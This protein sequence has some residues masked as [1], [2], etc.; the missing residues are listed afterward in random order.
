MVILLKVVKLIVD[1][2]DGM[3]IDDSSIN[4]TSISNSNS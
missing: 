3:N 4:N 2:G 1:D